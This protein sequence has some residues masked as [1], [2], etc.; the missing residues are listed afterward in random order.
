MKTDL[1]ELQ[2]KLKQK[3]NVIIQNKSA[4]NGKTVN[5][6]FEKTGR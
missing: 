6:F 1:K 3:Y 2:E 4:W 5:D